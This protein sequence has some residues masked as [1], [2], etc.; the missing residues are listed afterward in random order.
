M[1]SRR[2]SIVGEFRVERVRVG[3]ACLLTLHGGAARPCARPDARAARNVAGRSE[4]RKKILETAD[5]S[6]RTAARRCARPRSA[7]LAR[8][9]LTRARAWEDAARARIARWWIEWITMLQP[10]A[11]TPLPLGSVRPTGWLRN[12]LRIQ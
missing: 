1:R 11:F 12:Q 6:A 5:F 7:R 9:R 2:S 8:G 3:I 4:T 10:L